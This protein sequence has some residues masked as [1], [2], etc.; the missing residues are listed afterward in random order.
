MGRN[1]QKH[2]RPVNGILLLDKPAGVRSNTALQRLKRAYGARK[3]GHTGSLDSPASGLLPIC[4]GE[5][6][7]MS[8]FLLD[9]DKRYLATFRLGACTT[10]GDAQGEVLIERP[11]EDYSDAQIES[12]LAQFRG[13]IEQVPPMFSALKHEGKR[14]YELAYKGQTVEREPRKLHIYEL[15]L[16]ERNS[17]ELKVHI[18]CSK[19]TYV[20]TLAT[21]IGEQ[22]GCG[23]HVSQLRR[24]SVGPFD[25][26]NMS[27]LEALEALAKSGDI[28]A[29]DQLLL[30]LDTALMGMPQV[31]LAES[32]VFY[33]RRGQAV[34][35]PKAPTE[36]LVRIY[37]K[38]RQ[39][40][41]VGVVLDDGRIAPRRLLV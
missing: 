4:F 29:L 5:A 3:A 10:T 37:S 7:K 34:L 26:Q 8:G 11:V 12:V 24:I 21:D 6:T 2:G 40:M 13:D 32:S 38:S 14:L 28:D 36:G 15:R 1:R 31:E 17:T 9:A 39:F 35:V 18:H 16:V 20:R 22:L 30:P 41:G 27:Q 23:G 33:L 25:D 19:G